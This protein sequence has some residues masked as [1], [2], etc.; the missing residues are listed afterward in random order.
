MFIIWF[1]A[2]VTWEPLCCDEC[3]GIYKT[4]LDL[5][6]LQ[7][8]NEPEITMAAAWNVGIWISTTISNISIRS[9]FFSLTQFRLLYLFA[10]LECLKWN[11]MKIVW[12]ATFNKHTVG[13][14]QLPTSQHFISSTGEPNQMNEC[15]CG[16]QTNHMEILLLQDR[17]Q[18]K[19]DLPIRHMN[20][21]VCV[22]VS[23]VR[24]VRSTDI[25]VADVM[26]I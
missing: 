13:G 26:W 12:K 9:V 18:Y 19:T 25:N 20:P 14:I 6:A 2:N 24:S 5:I 11:F 10:W 1:C 21:C 16:F 17:R 3:V 23:N 22:C 4:H 8:L 7:N 15:Q